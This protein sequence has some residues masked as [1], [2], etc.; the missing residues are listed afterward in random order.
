MKALVFISYSHVNKDIARR[1]SKRL[2]GIGLDHFL[3]EKDISW[4]SSISQEVSQ[5]LADCVALIVIVSASSL[6]STW[7]PFEIGQ[8]M[9]AN[10]KILPVITDPAL[11]V[12]IYISNLSYVTDINAAVKYFKSDSWKQHLATLTASPSRVNSKE[13]IS[14]P[15]YRALLTAL[16][17]LTDAYVHYSSKPPTMTLEEYAERENVVKE[18]LFEN[19]LNCDPEVYQHAAQVIIKMR[20]FFDI[21]NQLSMLIGGDGRPDKKKLGEQDKELDEDLDLIEK[22]I[23]SLN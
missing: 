15:N 12:P 22:K 8:A 17:R 7:V 3:D 18:W 19:K 14:R 9:S 4:G 13:E 23:R 1:L 21:G 10:K 2:E 6:K 5:A 16:H 11:D 20:K